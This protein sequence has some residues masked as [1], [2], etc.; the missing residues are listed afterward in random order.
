MAYTGAGLEWGSQYRPG[1]AAAFK[2]PP[3]SSSASAASLREQLQ[4]QKY[5]DGASIPWLLAPPKHTGGRPLPGPRLVQSA[6]QHRPTTMQDTPLHAASK[7][8]LGASSSVHPQ[9]GQQQLQGLNA[10]FS[11]YQAA[12]KQPHSSSGRS[13][14][15][16]RH[17]GAA[18]P[19][20][21]SYDL[22]KYGALRGSAQT[23]R[24]AFCRPLVLDRFGRSALQ[25]S[26]RPERVPQGQQP[27]K[28][29]R[30]CKPQADSYPQEHT[31]SGMSAYHKVRCRSCSPP[32]SH[33]PGVRAGFRSCSP[34]HTE[35]LLAAADA[36]MAGAPGP[37]YYN[38][39]Q[40]PR[41]VSYR[42]AR[43]AGSTFVA[44]V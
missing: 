24:S 10:V 18:A 44:V 17:G 20:P 12:N 4:Q 28:P 1:A 15:Q 43:S 42:Q 14:W 35:A 39:Q 5:G 9:Q 29:D 37:S 27:H 2:A 30:Q 33:Q 23:H 40:Q 7:A 8:A 41:K 32:S 34:G 25:S 16:M 31:A 22:S 6:H 11:G 36:D 13:S 19:G 21:G 26:M 38:P 3:R